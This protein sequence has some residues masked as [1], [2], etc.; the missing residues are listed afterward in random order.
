MELGKIFEANIEALE[1][2]H[3]ASYQRLEPE[4]TKFRQNPETDG[5]RSVKI[6]KAGEV[7]N[8]HYEQKEPL[9]RYLCHAEDPM[10]EA[11][12][13]LKDAKLE[14]PQMVFFFGLGLG[15]ALQIFMKNRPDKNF[16]VAVIEP[17]TW[18]FLSALR[19]SDF[20]EFLS[21]SGSM[22]MVGLQTTELL[23]PLM[24]LSARFT[25][26]SRFV[27][28][29]ALPKELQ[30]HAEYFKAAAEL[31]MKSRDHSVFAGGNSIED[32]FIG[33][34]NILGN[35]RRAVGNTGITPYTGIVP[36]GK[37]ILSIAAG[38]SLDDH[39]DHI[40]AWYGKVPII[41]CDVLLK[42]MLARGIVPDIVTAVERTEVVT[43]FF[44]DV[45][46]P[47]RPMLVGPLLLR[48]ETFAAFQG[49]AAMYCPP[50]QVSSGIGLD[51]LGLFFPGSSAGNLNVS[52]ACHMGF[53]N[54]IMVG[55]NLAFGL[56]SNRTHVIGTPLQFQDIPL[57]DEEIAKRSTGLRVK[58]QDG[59]DLVPT[60]P[61]WNQFREQME[62]LISTAPGSN[63]INTAPKGAHIAGT[64]LM[65][66]EDAMKEY[67][68]EPF[69]FYEHRQKLV[70]PIDSE[71][72]ASRESD[73]LE[74]VRG[75]RE[76]LMHWLDE[77]Q[78]VM[79]K[80]ERWKSEI[81]DRENRK[82]PVSLHYLD[83]AIEDVLRIKVQ[84]VNEDRLFYA[85]AITV[86]LPAHLA[87]ERELNA[88]PGHY[89]DNYLLK[90]DFLLKHANY[91]G[92]WA[93]WIPKLIDV[94]GTH[95]ESQTSVA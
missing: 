23:H 84:A 11:R 76:R 2:Y 6:V 45:P 32:S 22:V 1:K 85:G 30:S 55:Q 34:Q 43:S 26:V 42:P 81:E 73:V 70:A 58:T 59:L 69:D 33:Y 95:G 64:K 82:R 56:G 47:K 10:A 48:P 94:L 12:Q 86:L 80:L 68:S 71:T 19:L 88:M 75:A 21:A 29:V 37:T 66:F 5:N 74:A 49:D 8:L 17:D 79:K 36:P 51:F 13:C 46:L 25:T 14:M 53:Q 63:F 4:I 24:A 61:F 83:D 50:T 91:F 78:R 38:P 89:R 35:I 44:Q 57:T 3:P 27:N 72:R 90:R 62:A 7:F 92:M 31:I 20:T 16:S 28:I 9:R 52:F 87:F 18:V 67:A 39:W 15:Y 54:I 93:R 40:K 65:S 77:A 41:C 60:T